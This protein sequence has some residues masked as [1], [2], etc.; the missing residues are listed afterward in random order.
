MNSKFLNS[1][2]PSLLFLEDGECITIAQKSRRC[3]NRLQD[4]RRKRRCD[5]NFVPSV[6]TKEVRHGT[7][8]LQCKSRMAGFAE[9]PTSLTVHPLDE[10]CLNT[11][12]CAITPKSIR[13]RHC[14][15]MCDY[16]VLL[17]GG[18][19]TFTATAK[20]KDNIKMMWRYLRKNHFKHENIVTFVGNRYSLERK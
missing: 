1:K 9:C 3:T 4:R 2:F 19:N 17:S 10:K 7:Q 5:I 13:Q 15:A 11:K 18:W 8:L 20:S 16:A 14:T 6:F 12:R